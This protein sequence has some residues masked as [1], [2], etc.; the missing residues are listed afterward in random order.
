[1]ALPHDKGWRWLEGPIWRPFRRGGRFTISFGA[2]ADALR[3]ARQSAIDLLN[4][5]SK[6]L[7]Q[8]VDSYELSVYDLFDFESSISKFEIAYNAENSI[9]NLFVVTPKGGYNS[10]ALIEYGEVLFPSSIS[11][12]VPDSIADIRAAWKCIAF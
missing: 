9:E 2:S 11:L 4:S 8:D 1:M 12:K 3:T 7:K 5:I 6:I 10:T